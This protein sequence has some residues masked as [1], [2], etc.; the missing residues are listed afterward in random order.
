V[1]HSEIN[2]LVLIWIAC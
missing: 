2:V 1:I